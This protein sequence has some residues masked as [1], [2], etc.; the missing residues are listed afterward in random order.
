MILY[1]F[2]YHFLFIPS[3][4]IEHDNTGFGPG[5]FLERVVITD[6][7]NPKRGRFYFPCSQWLAKDEADGKI[8]RDLEGTRDRFGIRKSKTFSCFNNNCSKK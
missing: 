7:K 6:T 2:F 1:I 4:R 5:W 8:S 3:F